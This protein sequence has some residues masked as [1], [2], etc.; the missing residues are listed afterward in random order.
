MNR[1]I[2]PN[3][4]AILIGIVPSSVSAFVATFPTATFA[5]G[6]D[7]G[8]QI[9]GKDGWNLDGD[10]QY[11]PADSRGLSYSNFLGSSLGAQLG[12][13]YDVAPA[14]GEVYLWHSTP[15]ALDSASFSV[16]FVIQASNEFNLGRDE[17]GFSFRDAANT[18][19]FTISL[20]PV[21]GGDG[22]SYQV[23]YTVGSQTTVNAMDVN[24]DP[25]FISEN[26]PYS[27][28]FDFT[29]S[30]ANTNFTA[31]LDTTSFSGT[32]TGLG[33]ATIDRMC[34]E[35]NLVGDGGN[36][37]LLVDN[38]TLVPEPSAILLVSLSALGF[39]S[40]RKRG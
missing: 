18:N 24:N 31:M 3:L 14:N 17:F 33:A 29:P 2:L 13:N 6:N 36:N 37:G 11:N 32:A 26:S 8:A 7:V 16:T 9:A 34:M 19:L 10:P 40:R 30:G 27:L 4:T 23:R 38:I 35:W 21:S 1:F 25:L 22:D 20:V 5:P 28:A 39:A 15:Q 12:G